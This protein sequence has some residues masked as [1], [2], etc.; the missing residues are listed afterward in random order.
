[1]KQYF[2]K[3]G[4]ILIGLTC[5]TAMTSCVTS[6]T[7]KLSTVHNPA[8]MQSTG[9]RIGSDKHAMPTY[10]DE[11]RTRYVRATAYS[12]MEMEDG[13]PGRK[14]AAGSI[15]KYGSTRSAAADWSRLPLG[16]KFKIVGQPR[17]TYVVD[18]YGSALEGTNTID[19]F[20]PTLDGMNDWGTRYAVIQI[21]QMGSF[22]QSANI[23]SGRKHA[24]HC[25]NMFY[26]I[27]RKFGNSVARN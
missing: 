12:H 17:V 6:N 16:T 7:N 9:K 13:A 23:L 15:L 5:I 20:H 21:I 2:R 26:A 27:T 22:N 19:I 4:L 14:N 24:P 11:A 10:A 8:L 25:R 3:A 1:M 18:D